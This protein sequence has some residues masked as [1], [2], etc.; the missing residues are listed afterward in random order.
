MVKKNLYLFLKGS[1]YSNAF[2]YG[3]FN[4]KRIILY[5]TLFSNLTR[6]VNNVSKSDE[7]LAIVAHE[8]GHL[9]LDHILKIFII[10]M[11]KIIYFENL[12]SQNNFIL[13]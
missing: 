10:N 7:T 2:A 4:S 13:I 12:K 8:L 6:A 9:K 5:D 11:V 3:I 1:N